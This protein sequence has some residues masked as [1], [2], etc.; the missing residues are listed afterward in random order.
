MLNNC[1]E[2]QFTFTNL[3]LQGGATTGGRSLTAYVLVALLEAE[4]IASVS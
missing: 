1:V 2:H 3:I 4:S